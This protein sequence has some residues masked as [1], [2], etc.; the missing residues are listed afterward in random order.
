MHFKK[1]VLK[2]TRNLLYFNSFFALVNGKLIINNWIPACAGMTEVG[3][4]PPA[5]VYPANAGW[6]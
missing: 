5:G 1:H 3:R 6:E 2:Y 4:I